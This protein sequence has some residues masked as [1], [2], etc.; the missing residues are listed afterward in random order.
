M[1]IVT[2]VGS[3]GSVPEPA[4]SGRNL[5]HLKHEI[6]MIQNLK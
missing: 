4:T 3:A 5:G 1:P 6:E 2:G